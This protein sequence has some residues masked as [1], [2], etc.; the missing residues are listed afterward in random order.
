MSQPWHEQLSLTACQY[1]YLRTGGAPAGPSGVR[2]CPSRRAR[3]AGTTA[4]Q[5][6]LVVG[7]APSHRLHAQMQTNTRSRKRTQLHASARE[8]CRRL[9]TQRRRPL[10]HPLPP[11]ST[12][13]LRAGGQHTRTLTLQ[14]TGRFMGSGVHA[15]TVSCQADCR[16]CPSSARP[17]RARPGRPR[18]GSDI[19]SPPPRYC[20]IFPSSFFPSSNAWSIATAQDPHARTHGRGKETSPL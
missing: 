16:L 6:C 4:F 20:M 2:R 17:S 9:P 13:S 14:H 5:P 7:R 3:P 1:V 10:S 18:L 12:R 15:R 8:R 11:A 19:S